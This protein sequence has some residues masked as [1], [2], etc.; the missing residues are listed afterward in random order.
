MNQRHER[1]EG[2]IGR[3]E[4]RRRETRDEILRE[5]RRLVDGTRR[6]RLLHARRRQ[7]HRFH[8]AGALSVFPGRKG[9]GAPSPGHLGPRP[10]GRPFQARARRPAPGRT[11]ARD[12]HDL[13]GVRPRTPPGARH[14]ARERRGLQSPDV[15]RGRP[16]PPH[17]RVR[18]HRGGLR[19]R[20][21]G[22]GDQGLYTRG[23]SRWYSMALGLWCT[24][25]PSRRPCIP[26][27]ASSSA[28]T[29][30]TW[31]RAYLKGLRLLIGQER[32][33]EPPHLDRAPGAVV[34]RPPLADRGAMG[35]GRRRRVGSG[36]HTRW[37][38]VGGRRL[39][40]QS[41]EQ[42]GRDAHRG[43]PSRAGADTEIV[44]VR[45]AT[46]PWTIPP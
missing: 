1:D 40:E 10:P 27:T 44:V 41:R 43:T 38:P 9:R 29:P 6:R 30:A 42:A 20:G 17:G 35:T 37:R 19:R 11:P 15:E 24:A 36:L 31:C 45:S 4:R 33:H 32:G 2:S 13:S 21:R 18:A 5:A 8:P 12:R 22:R 25:W 3:K 39:H 16:P 7:E 14:H 46:P 23:D 26:T 28:S 34:G